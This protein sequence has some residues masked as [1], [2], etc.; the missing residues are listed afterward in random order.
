MIVYRRS[1][2]ALERLNM[3]F[4]YHLATLPGILCCTLV[5]MAPA[6]AQSTWHLE[7]TMQVGGAGGMDYITVDSATRRLYV[8]R[9][10][11]TMVIDAVTG[12]TLG[13]IPGQKIA[14]GVALVPRLN[15]GFITDGGGAG[16]VT[17][18]DLKTNAV[19]GVIAAVPDADGIIYD[20]GSDRI[21]VSAGDSNCL[22]TIKP[23]I[24]PKTGKIE[25]PIQLGGAPEF[26]AADGAGKAYV[27]LEN[28]DNVAVVDLK[29]RK[30]TAHWPVAPG[31]RPV[32]LALDRD[33]H[34]LIIG[35]RKPQKMIVMS[36]E[37]GK[38]LSDLP[39]GAGV[40][41]TRTQGTEAFASCGDGTLAVVTRSSAGTYDLTQTVTTARG[42]KTMDID[43]KTHT[44]YLPTADFEDAK[45]GATGR[46]VPK[47]GTFKILVV[48]R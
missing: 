7:K 27:N 24:D 25:P 33:H 41:A 38:V 11:H 40:D 19:L 2:S 8:T 17:V 13:D 28:K 6:Q 34:A 1:R 36:T 45:P 9:R 37:D 29:E 47:P 30:V 12:K 5:A 21:L 48:T 46:P 23:D 4:A 14:H 18:F 15:R 43:T 16:S 22:I 10:T 3:R 31:G 32:G 35:C 26:L 20:P 44:I 42:A 39:I